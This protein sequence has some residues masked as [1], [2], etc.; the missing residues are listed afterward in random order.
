MDD[1]PRHRHSVSF[2]LFLIAGGIY[3]LVWNLG[4]ATWSPWQVVTTFWPL[5]LVGVGLDLLLGR[6][7]GWIAI[8][9]AAV[10]LAAL[11]AGVLALSRH[12]A[13]SVWPGKLETTRVSVPLDGATS[14]RLDLDVAGGRLVLG[15][16]PVTD[17]DIVTGTATTYQGSRLLTSEVR[18]GDDLHASGR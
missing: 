12:V 16:G 3:L 5:L 13:G 4:L 10:I 9:L 1:R 18:D 11:A 8:P 15:A 6:V 17:D 2:P 14:A 7:S